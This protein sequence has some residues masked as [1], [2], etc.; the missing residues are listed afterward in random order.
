MGNPKF[1]PVHGVMNRLFFDLDIAN[2][3]PDK[4]TQGLIVIAS[5]VSDF[6]S[7]TGLAQD[8]LH[9]IVMALWPVPAFFQLPAID[10]VAHQIQVF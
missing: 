8:F 9:D 2:G 6:G 3:N 7:L 4:L 1:A 10:N 5:D